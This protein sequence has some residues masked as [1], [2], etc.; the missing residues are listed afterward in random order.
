MLLGR[1]QVRA[2][3]S[4][5]ITDVSASDSGI[6]A[7]EAKNEAGSSN[8]LG[9][10][11]VIV[12]PE[13]KEK[14]DDTL[15]RVGADFTLQCKVEGDPEPLLVW[16]L[17][18]Q[19]QNVIFSGSKN[20]KHASLSENGTILKVSKP[21]KDDTGDYYCWGISSWGGVSSKAEVVVVD[22]FPPPL[23]GVRPLDQRVTPGSKVEFPCEVASEAAEAKITWWFQEA[24]HLPA[25]EIL[26]KRSVTQ[27]P[28]G[29]L[30][31]KQVSERDAGIYTCRVSSE[32][33]AVEEE[34]I[35]RV[36]KDVSID[37]N[38]GLSLAQQGVPAPP[39]KPRIMYYNSSA[40]HLTWLPNSRGTF[41]DADFYTI[42]YW[43]APWQEWRVAKAEVKDTAATLTDLNPETAY[44]FLVRA[45]N[46]GRKSFP[47]PWSDVI[48]TT[49]F[50]SHEVSLEEE[51]QARRRLNKPSI[52]LLSAKTLSPRSVSLKWELLENE[53][54][55]ADGILV[56]SIGETSSETAIIYSAASTSHVIKNLRPNTHYTF[57]LVPFWR[58]MEGV[59]SNS[60]NLVTP[61]EGKINSQ[62]YFSFWNF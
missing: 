8:A 12:A 5:R 40:A 36:E 17:P 46:G 30:I 28:N 60:Q 13:M 4:L 50:G 39:S 11:K 45:V 31:L 3:N 35:L 48:Y 6:Y 54:A 25:Q 19:D 32:A 55:E 61:E 33:G 10:L 49:P 53:E 7:C 24:A 34:A 62:Y 1:A 18:H 52:A 58:T 15:A 2:K 38:E 9:F 44:T 26:Y 22:A 51:R 20:N 14:P 42:E 57:F 59:P 16:K 29:K 43:R 37:Y 27:L 56:Y 23:I 21:Q 41:Q 47:S